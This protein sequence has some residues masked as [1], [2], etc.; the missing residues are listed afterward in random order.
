MANAQP[1]HN[2]QTKINQWVRENVPHPHFF[3]AVDRRK[4]S[5]MFS[6]VREKARGHVA[7]TPDTVLL[8]PGLCCI[9]IELKA[10]RKTP[11]ENQEQVGAVIQEAGHFWGWCDSVA[12][13]CALLVRAG[14]PLG[15]LAAL[16]AERKDAVLEGA[17]IR[18]EEAR[19][20]KVSR[21]R[22]RGAEK[23]SAAKIAR[24]VARQ[25]RVPH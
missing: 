18:R 12:G 22:Y 20:G 24:S 6:H 7:G 4:K 1:E 23:P 25:G 10:P 17:A 16:N 2:L 19:T 3:F 21:K 13:Y 11:D 5:G 15:P 14:V 8:F 9:T